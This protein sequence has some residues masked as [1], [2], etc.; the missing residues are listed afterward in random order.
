MQIVG[1]CTYFERECKHP[2]LFDL[3]MFQGYL[4]VTSI[5]V[6]FKF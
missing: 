6:L 4:L 1:G 2:N 3:V 5:D